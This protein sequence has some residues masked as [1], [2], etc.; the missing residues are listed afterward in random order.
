MCPSR[1]CLVLFLSL[2]LLAGL[3]SCG[4]AAPDNAPN[5]ESRTSAVPPWMAKELDSPDVGTRL[6]A[7]DTWVQLAPEGAVDPLILAFEDQDE[8]VQARAMELI[9]KSLAS[10]FD[11]EQ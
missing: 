3:A 2:M 11:V 5:P 10:E 7:L 9:E 1:R 8:R 6:Q 4:P